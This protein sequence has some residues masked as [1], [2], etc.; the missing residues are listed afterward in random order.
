MLSA[1]ED[2]LS[3]LK[4][5]WPGWQIWTVRTWDGRRAGKVWC[6]RPR[7]RV[8]PVINAHTWQHLDEY[9]DEAAQAGEA[10]AGGLTGQA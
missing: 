8:Q 4:A 3:K 9:L 2:G 7:G 5:R 6:A 1:M 10:S